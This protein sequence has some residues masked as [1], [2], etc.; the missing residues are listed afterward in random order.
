MKLITVIFIGL[1]T[2][3]SG[4][5]Y[6]R[7]NRIVKGFGDSGWVS[8]TEDAPQESERKEEV[9]QAAKKQHGLMH[10]HRYGPG[11]DILLT[12][13]AGDSD[14]KFVMALPDGK[15]VQESPQPESDA[16]DFDEESETAEDLPDPA[17]NH[18][19]MAERIKE[20]EQEKAQVVEQT[21][22]HILNAQSMFYKKEYWKALDETNAAL[23]RLPTSAQAHALKGSI[24][25][26]MGLIPEAKASWEEALSLD[27]EMDQVKTSLARIQ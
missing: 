26:K 11:Y 27:P 14:V 20:L 25:Y 5:S 4:C 10:I 16:V 23:E 18:Q 6:E 1:V 24:Y 7:N 19:Q 22:R 13:D 8:E 12:L 21:T 15:E 3:L 2:F 17:E 9:A